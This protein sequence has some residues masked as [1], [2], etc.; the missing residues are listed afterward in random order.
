ALIRPARARVGDDVAEGEDDRTRTLRGSLLQTAAVVAGDEG[1][2]ARSRELLE[3]FLDD[4]AGVDASLSAAALAAAATLGDVALHERLVE[5]FGAADNPQDRERI[6]RSLARF[7]DAEAL[8]RTLDLTL[9]GSVRTQDAPYLLG[10]TLANRDNA[11]AAWAFVSGHWDEVNER[12]PANSIARLVGGIR[13]VRERALADDI[14]AFLADHPVP[15][16]ELQVRQHVERMGVTVA[17]A[18]REAE[19]LAAALTA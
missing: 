12:F 7:R 2:Q 11:A 15:Q 18:E 14:A 13:S 9:S 1:A 5:R 19:R 10:E 8:Q 3:R 4:P 6:L 16:G 17:L